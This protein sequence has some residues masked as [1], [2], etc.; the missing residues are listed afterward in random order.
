MI[1]DVSFLANLVI[2]DI[3]NYTCSM[4]YQDVS[5]PFCHNCHLSL[6]LS[7]CVCVPMCLAIFVLHLIITYFLQGYLS[8]MS[9][10]S[11]IYCCFSLPWFEVSH[12]Y[13]IIFLLQTPGREFLLRV[14]YLEIYNEVITEHY[15]QI[16]FMLNMVYCFFPF[17]DHYSRCVILLH[18][19]CLFFVGHISKIYVLMGIWWLYLLGFRW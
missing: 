2:I 3:L 6:S 4:K 7:L 18:A 10:L 8:S 9:W 16:M 17:N 15:C 13:L 1:Q 14:S 11:I 19:Y 5:V 12:L